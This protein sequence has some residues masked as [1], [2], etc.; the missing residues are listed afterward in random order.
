MARG[1]KPVRSAHESRRERTAAPR[2]APPSPPPAAPAPPARRAPGAIAPLPARGSYEIPSGHEMDEVRPVTAL[3]ADIVG[4]TGLGE[5]LPPDQVKVLVGECVSRMTQTVERYGGVVQV[6]DPVQ[7]TERA[8]SPDALGH[9]GAAAD[10]ASPAACRGSRRWP[11]PSQVAP[12]NPDNASQARSRHP[13][14]HAFL[15]IVELSARPARLVAALKI[16]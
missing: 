11:A 10:R 6:T 16:R 12:T 9:S 3:F 15:Q 2:P 7:A 4:S 5:R 14:E 1:A 13:P 8:G